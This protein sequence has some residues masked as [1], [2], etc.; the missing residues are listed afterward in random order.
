[1]LTDEER[2]RALRC[3]LKNHDWEVFPQ[4]RLEKEDAAALLNLF[5][6]AFA[7]VDEKNN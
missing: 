2:I 1:M 3:N 5:S 4:F 6:R 7:Q